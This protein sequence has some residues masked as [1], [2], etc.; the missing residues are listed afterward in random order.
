MSYSQL[1]PYLIQSSL[2]EPKSLRPLSEPYP[3]GYDHDMQCGYHAR[4][5]GH[6]TEDCNAF[7]AKV[8]QL[9]DKRYISFSEGS[10]LVHINLS[11]EWV[12]RFHRV[13]HNAIN[14][15]GKTSSTLAIV[16][17]ICFYFCIYNFFVVKSFLCLNIVVKREMTLSLQFLSSIIWIQVL[18]LG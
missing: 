15:D 4:T 16:G 3:P 10:L 7:K 2:V 17:L 8:Q 9:I 5:I 1:L 14:S 13:S 18:L 11:S 6:S 12:Q